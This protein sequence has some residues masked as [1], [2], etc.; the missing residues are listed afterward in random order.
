MCPHNGSL[1][2]T[3]CTFSS[4]SSFTCYPSLQRKVIFIT[5]GASGIGAAMV[6]AFAL[7][8]ALVFFVDINPKEGLALEQ[9]LQDQHLFATFHLCDVSC[10]SS[11]KKSIDIAQHQYG[12]ISVLINNAA[13]DQRQPLSEINADTWQKTMSLNLSPA[14]FASQAVVDMMKQLGGGAIINLSSINALF[15]QKNMADYITAKAGL[16]GMT[17]A[18]A[19]ELGEFNIR[20]NAILPGWIATERQLEHWLTPEAERKWNESL[21]IKKR[22]TADD[23]ANLALFLAADDSRMITAQNFVIDGGKS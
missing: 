7:Q 12:D 14:F 21:C 23:V 13:N 22:I 15:G 2:K 11:L 6:N 3:S 17:K 1:N 18:L 4:M 19:A 16:L 20:A 5:G 10:T 9:Q 8:G